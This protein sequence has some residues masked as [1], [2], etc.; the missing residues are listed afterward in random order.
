MR[1]PYSTRSRFALIDALNAEWDDL[2]RDRLLAAHNRAVVAQWASDNPVLSGC[3]NP[4]AVLEAI[5]ADPDPVL[6]ALIAIHQSLR[7]PGSGAEDHLAGRIVLQA[8]LGKIVTMAGKDSRHAVED[9]VGQLWAR[10]DSYPLARRPRRIAA[11]LALDTLK[12]VTHDTDGRDMPVTADEL[13]LA[14]LGHTVTTAGPGLSDID[15]V[16]DLTVH[17]VLRTA[18]LLGLID[19]PTRRLLLS[20]YAEGLTSAD[21]ATRHGLTPATVRFRCSKA[22]RR[23]AQ[24]A[25]TIAEAA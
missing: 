22:I 9:Y 15:E 1:K 16:A 23:M 20:V 4:G 8:M 10:I 24:H 21:A 18:H 11:N 2:D 3:G 19:E 6:A 7:A 17:R 12:A 5:R 14:G 13:E 25:M